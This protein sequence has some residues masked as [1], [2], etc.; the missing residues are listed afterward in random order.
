MSN[1]MGGIKRKEAPSAAG[2]IEKKQKTGGYK[3]EKPAKPSR[4]EQ[5][6]ND[7]GE[8]D[9][10]D[11]ATMNSERADM[12]KK[13]MSNTNAKFK[14]DTSSA[15]AHAKQRQLAKE[16]KAAKPNADVVHRSKQLWEK[17]RRK[18]HVPKEE[19]EELLTELFSI[20]DG[21]VRDFVF[22]HDSV[23]VVQC[24]IKYAR[25]AQLKG[26]VKELQNDV[27][28][29]VESRYGKFLVAKMVVQ[30][31]RAD[32]DMIIPQFYGNIKRL[33]NHPEASWILDDIYRQ[34]ATPKQKAMI[35]R[36][37]Y[38]AE[39][40][41][42]GKQYTKKSPPADVTA[43]LV[44][45][46]E[47]NPEKRK[48]ILGYLKQL[49][50][51]L[52]QKKMTGFTMLHD[53]MLQYFLALQPG[54]EEQSEFLEI[55]RNDI[56][57]EENDGG[58]DLYR[59]LAFT[60]S[61]S[62]L[63]C[64]ALAHGSAKA[65][66]QILKCF[67]DHIE[68]MAFDIHARM[69][70]VAGLD[71]T[72]DTKLTSQ[73]VLT[74]LLGL[75]NEDTKSKHDRLEAMLTNLHSRLPILFPL[76][77]TAKWLCQAGE[78]EAIK[79]IHAVRATT[80]KKAPSQRRDEL[81]KTV[82]EP[83]LELVADRASNLITSSF[84]TQA[85]SEIL[86]SCNAS[87]RATA[88]EAVAA[89]AE[90]DPHSEDHIAKD[91]AVGRMLKTLVTGGAFDP[92]TKTVVL[93]EPRLGF[94]AILYPQIKEHIVSWAT[95]DSSFVVVALLES[96]DL[97]EG[98]KKKVRKALE[99]GKLEIKKAAEASSE[100]K[101]EKTSDEEEETGK[102]KK[103]KVEHKGNAGARILLEKLG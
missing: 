84:G 11:T 49:I 63:V 9:D 60:K 5:A 31:D 40:A 47:T 93:S 13:P 90:G 18:S 75:K 82:S 76:A 16:R 72:D 80:S 54:S 79:E 69:V 3:Y 87:N 32:K 61:G 29:L 103:R 38:G 102:S 101:A 6:A 58:G 36:E 15:E 86:L 39:Y 55:L 66:K 25:P 62:R 64:L 53:A 48:P 37:W 57:A 91:P 71:V 19:R 34:V 67:K 88:A 35:L 43:D 65:R 74:E 96:E 81:L 20:I 12:V 45:I 24:A 44:K 33:I 4:L 100:G 59:N 8:D 98:I 27:R 51:N 22:K 17:L 42:E 97:D 52:I 99:K 94:G 78:K 68:T 26:I 46:L 89:L 7:D 85:I 70:L 10:V 83:L 28:D 30:G 92:A 56:D 50:N 2:K 23:R 73:T 77:G 41:I 1:K 14:L 21:R 95:S